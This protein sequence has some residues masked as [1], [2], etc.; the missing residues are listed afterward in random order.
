MTNKKTVLTFLIG[1]VVG[2]ILAMFFTNRYVITKANVSGGESALE[3]IYRTDR[4]T[5]RT[6]HTNYFMDQWEEIKDPN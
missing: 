5:G 1:L 4:W 6:F 2:F 3:E